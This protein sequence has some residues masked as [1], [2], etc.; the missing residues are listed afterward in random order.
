[1]TD[2]D[3]FILDASHNPVAVDALTWAA[4]FETIDNR[5]VAEDIGEDRKGK[6]RLSSICLGF[7]HSFGNG[8]P[9]LFETM[10]FR[11]DGSADDHCDCWRFS[12]WEDCMGFHRRMVGQ[13]KGIRLVSGAVP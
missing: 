1:M 9:I 5:R 3:Y 8:P 13:L 6:W 12:S 7:N 11:Q 10:L 2:L 4:W